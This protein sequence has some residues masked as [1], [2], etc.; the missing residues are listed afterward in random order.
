MT[1]E[2][3]LHKFAKEFQQKAEAASGRV[4]LG[5]L[6]TLDFMEKHTQSDSLSKFVEAYDHTI[7]NETFAESLTPEFDI[8]ISENSKFNNWDEMYKK[9]GEEYFVR[10][11]KF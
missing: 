1:F 11:L 5:E 9:A 3:N 8:Y 2:N 4:S 6:F 7:T 10:K